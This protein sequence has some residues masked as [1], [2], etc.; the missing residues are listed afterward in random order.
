MDDKL[1]CPYCGSS[2]VRRL[3]AMITVRLVERPEGGP[4]RER[5]CRVY[6]CLACGHSFDEIEAEEGPEPEEDGGPSFD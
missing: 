4:A 1:S 3:D 2:Q 5:R 6:R